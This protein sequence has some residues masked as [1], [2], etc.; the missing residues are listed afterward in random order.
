MS[1]FFCAVFVVVIILLLAKLR[2]PNTSTQ[3]C[4]YVIVLGDL[5]RSP[6]MCNHA[7]QF[8]KHRFS[9]KLI[10]YAGEYVLLKD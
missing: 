9:V 1:P 5:G 2:K 8:A 4:A 6:R 10:G 7:I 3:R